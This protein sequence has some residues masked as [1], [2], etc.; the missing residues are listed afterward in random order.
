MSLAWASASRQEKKSKSSHRHSK[1]HSEDAVVYEAARAWV[2]RSLRKRRATFGNLG[3]RSALGFRASH[4]GA[5]FRY[6]S[7]ET[8]KERLQVWKNPGL[9]PGAG[10]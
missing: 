1:K 3:Q 2:E 10:R 5:N 9:V 6:M 7:P 8:P 4:Q